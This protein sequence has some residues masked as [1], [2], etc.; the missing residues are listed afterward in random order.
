M[1]RNLYFPG[2]CLPCLPT[3]VD[4]PHRPTL[5]LTKLLIGATISAK[6][7]HNSDT[8]FIGLHSLSSTSEFFYYCYSIFTPIIPPPPPPPPLFSPPPPPHQINLLAPPPPLTPPPPPLHHKFSTPQLPARFSL[9]IAD[10]V[11]QLPRPALGTVRYGRTVTRR[12]RLLPY[13]PLPAY[14]RSAALP[15]AALLCP[16]LRCPRLLES[17]FPPPPTPA[18]AQTVDQTFLDIP[19]HKP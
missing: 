10:Q 19:N 16:T 1:P 8:T 6:Q 15:Y 18:G 17:S 11:G 5:I 13:P 14:F 2:Y 7:H 3:A 4:R 12:A 9:T